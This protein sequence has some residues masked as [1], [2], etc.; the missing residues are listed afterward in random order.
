MLNDKTIF[1]RERSHWRK[2]VMKETENRQV[3]GENK[4]VILFGQST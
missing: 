3:K 1:Y 4:N 2:K